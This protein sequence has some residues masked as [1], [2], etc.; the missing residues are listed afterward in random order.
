[1]EEVPPISPTVLTDAERRLVPF[2]M[3]DC[4]LDEIAVRLDLRPSTVKA[5]Q[6][7]VFRKLGIHDRVTLVR[8]GIRHDVIS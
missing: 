7:S 8:W 3:Q 4:S 2:L 5:L 6:L 1:M